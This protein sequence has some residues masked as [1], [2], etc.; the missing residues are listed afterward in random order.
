MRSKDMT[1]H[2]SERPQHLGIP[3]W[4]AAYFQRTPLR[5]R[6]VLPLERC[7]TKRRDGKELH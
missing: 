4:D 3:I 7:S 6:R 2:W 1:S 5:P